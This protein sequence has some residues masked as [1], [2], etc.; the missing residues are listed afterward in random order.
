MS[1]TEAI[2]SVEATVGGWMGC[3]CAVLVWSVC[4]VAC[5]PYLHGS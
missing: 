1:V 2:H 4:T 5:L 3:C